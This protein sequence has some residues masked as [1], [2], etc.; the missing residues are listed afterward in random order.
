MVS[1]FVKRA[2]VSALFAAAF[3]MSIAA[4]AD[5]GGNCCAD[6]EERIAELEATAARKG[7]RKVSLQITGFVAKQIAFFDDGLEQNVHITDTGSISIGSHVRFQGEAQILPGWAA[8]YS[9]NLEAV[10]SD[11]LLVNQNTDNNVGSA[12]AGGGRQIAVENSYWYIRSDQLGKLSVGKQSSA[13]DNQAILPDASGSLIQA[14]YV[15]YDTNNFFLRN[16]NGSLSGVVYGQLANCQALNGAGG[17]A[18]DCDGIPANVVRYDSPVFAGFSASFSWGEDDVWA[19]SG[20]YT[21]EF[22]GFKFNGAVAYFESSDESIGNAGAQANGGLDV[23]GIQFGG[24]LEHLA[25]GLWVYGAYGRD[26]NDV[27]SAARGAGRT[28]PEG[29]NWY[30]KGGIRESWTALGHTVLYGEYGQNN[31]RFTSQLYDAGVDTTNLRQWGV[32]LVQEL[33][34]AAM[35]LWVAW[36]HIEADDIACTD[37]AAGSCTAAGLINGVSRFDNLDIVKAGALINF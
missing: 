19:V 17:A 23:A 14:N 6:L 10:T 36:R 35:S 21:G 9:L 33:D 29:D 5:L 7:N 2:A 22:S 4:A 26:F 20:R 24:Y 31:D 8:G 11:S 27:T 30:I 16:Q 18:A 3:P 34:S 25:T 32:G 37:R 28:S 15:L 12:L 1:T 13:A